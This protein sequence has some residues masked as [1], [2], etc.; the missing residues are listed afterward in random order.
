MAGRALVV[1]VVDDVDEIRPVPVVA[2]S[3]SQTDGCTALLI[4]EDNLLGCGLDGPLNPP[5]RDP[6]PVSVGDIRSSL[7]KELEGL[8]F[9]DPDPCPF[10]D[11]QGAVVK[12]LDLRIRQTPVI[13][14]IQ[15]HE[16]GFHKI[17]PLWKS[18]CS[19]LSRKHEF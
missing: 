19:C 8:L 15:G 13:G 12:D 16:I 11:L 10:Q 18:Y 3:S 7:F 5:G 1:A 9:E 6:H 14:G 17:S 4:I 2:V